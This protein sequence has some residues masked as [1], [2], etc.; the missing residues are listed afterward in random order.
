MVKYAILGVEGPQDQAIVGK[1][2]KLLGLKKFDGSVSNLDSF[3]KKFIPTYPKKGNFY[4]RLDMPSILFNDS[5]SIAIYVGEGS[6]LVKNLDDILSNNSQYRNDIAAFGIVADADKKNPEDVVAEYYSDLCKYFPNFPNQPGFV[7]INI[8]RTG[9]Y[10]LP[11]N[12][13]HGVLDTLLCE[14]GKVAYPEYMERAKSYLADFSEQE[15]KSLK[16]KP[17]DR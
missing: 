1:L 14:C 8:P 13:S 16:W 10:V 3:W 11:D 12:I 9:I 5:L 7:D 4:K 6:N 15:Q 2:L 17:F